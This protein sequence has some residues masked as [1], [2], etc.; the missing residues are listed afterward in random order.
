MPCWLKHHLP[1]ASF[2]A[3]SGVF[4]GVESSVCEIGVTLLAVSIW[5]QLGRDAGRAIAIGVGAGAWE[6]FLL[7]AFVLA[8][9]AVAVTGL[10]V[11]EEIRQG[12]AESQA[13]SQRRCSGL[14]V[15]CNEC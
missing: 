5:R 13:R 8:S 6:A 15:P 11:G 2:V 3:A 1:Y 9:V 7:G 14:S 10:P 4:I 12:L